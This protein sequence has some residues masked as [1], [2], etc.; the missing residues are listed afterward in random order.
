VHTIHDSR[1]T[2]AVCRALG[3]DGEPARDA[4]TIAHQLGHATERMVLDIYAKQNIEE[5]QRMIEMRAAKARQA[6]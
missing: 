1:H 6:A 4:K 3:L 2:Y 5:R